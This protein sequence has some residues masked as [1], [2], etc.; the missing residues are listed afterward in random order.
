MGLQ[1][2]LNPFGQQFAL[3]K[4]CLEQGGGAGNDQRDRIRARDEEVCSSSTVNT[5]SISR[6]AILGVFGRG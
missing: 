6:S 1:Q 3:V 2:L 4:H 5:S